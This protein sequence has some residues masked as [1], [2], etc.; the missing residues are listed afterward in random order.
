[1]AVSSRGSPAP[2][3]TAEFAES[4]TE[5][6]A[7]AAGA[8]PAETAVVPTYAAAGKPSAPAAVAARMPPAAGR[9]SAAWPPAPIV[10]ATAG[11]ERW[12]VCWRIED[13]RQDRNRR[14]GQRDR[15]RCNL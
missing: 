6:A 2:V 4:A 15:Q 14:R 3:A 11:L 12:I 9:P 13:W 8:N 5:P 10:V 1:M 7:V